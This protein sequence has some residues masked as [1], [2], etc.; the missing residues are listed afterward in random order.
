MPARTVRGLTVCRFSLIAQA[1][2][3]MT[4]SPKPDCSRSIA[5]L[6]ALSL[7]EV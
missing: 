6:P 1:I 5:A 7:R 2:A 3:K 4:I